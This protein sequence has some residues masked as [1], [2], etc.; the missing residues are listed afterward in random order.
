MLWLTL[1]RHKDPENEIVER[2]QLGLA[3][4]FFTL[5]V[6]LAFGAQ[7]TSALWAVKAPRCFGTV[8][9]P[10]ACCRRPPGS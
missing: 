2:S 3:I 1:F 10:G 8:S 5:A 9:G 6:P 4:A 7:V